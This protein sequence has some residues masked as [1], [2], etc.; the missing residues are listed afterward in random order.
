[1]P[2]PAARAGTTVVAPP[3]SVAVP[4]LPTAG[5]AEPTLA[6][7]V[8]A[9]V[10]QVAATPVSV[11]PTSVPISM[12]GAPAAGHGAPTTPAPTLAPLDRGA[13]RSGDTPPEPGALGGPRLEPSG[14]SGPGGPY[15]DLCDPPYALDLSVGRTLTTWTEGL[16]ATQ[17]VA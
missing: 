15:A 7:P 9:P 1:V 5:A 13:D 16:T 3:A 17:A 2:A 4:G 14:P 11:S 10:S 12:S 8:T 6:A